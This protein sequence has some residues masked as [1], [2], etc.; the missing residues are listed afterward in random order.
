MTSPKVIARLQAKGADPLRIARAV[1]RTPADIPALVEGLGARKAAIKFGC[2][3]VLR[4]LSELN[5]RLV[6]PYFDTFVRL[7]DCDNNFL[8]WGAIVTLSHLAA[9]DSQRRFERI[10][11]KYYAPITGP[12]MVTAAQI[13]ASSPRIAAAKP[14]LTQRIVKEILKVQRAAYELHGKRSPECRN[15][16]FGHALVV[17]GALY[18]WVE[19]KQPV[20]AFIAKG[21]ECSRPS[22]RETAEKLFAE[23]E[24]LPR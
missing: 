17:L 5:P 15:V 2:E 20:L 1:A 18:P 9:V 24:R 23:I 12:V 11:A 10:F 19:K 3:K 6:Y 22:V 13:I 7:L 14:E 21:R 16:V 8:K 4:S